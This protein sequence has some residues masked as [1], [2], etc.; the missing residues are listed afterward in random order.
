MS[1]GTQSLS[2]LR[3]VAG[4]AGPAPGGF[5]M[6]GDV[7]PTTQGTWIERT[8]RDAGGRHAVNRY[9]MET[10][11]WP[12]KVYYLGTNSRWLGE[13][14]DVIGGFFADRLARDHFFEKWQESGMRLRRW[15]INAL[16]YYLL[17]LMK[18][19][20]SPRPAGDMD[21]AE[22]RYCGD[23]SAAMDRA[24]AVAFVRRAIIQAG[25]T[26]ANE[27][28]EAHWQVFLDHHL[29]GTPF[30]AIAARIGVDPFRAAVMSRTA[31]RKF[32]AALRQV[33][34]QDGVGPGEIDCEIRSL[35]EATGS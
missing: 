3:R 31:R 6:A 25:D 15:L 4:E 26:C 22:V 1:L 19:S 17:E 23:A 8:L 16:C 2:P 13:P 12:L 9:I 21:D 14:D 20:R 29:H 30:R 35:L 28:L 33:L 18:V 7:F 10:Y 32:R 27:G 24:A 5:P 11:A 34:I